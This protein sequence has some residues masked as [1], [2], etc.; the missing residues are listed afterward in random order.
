MSGEILLEEIHVQML[1]DELD[2]L[3]PRHGFDRDENPASAFSKQQA[4]IE[5]D[6]RDGLCAYLMS[7]ARA[8]HQVSGTTAASV[9]RHDDQD[10]ILRRRR[11]LT[12]VV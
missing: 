9:H 1:D 8:L 3:G 6:D 2:R 7:V 11:A 4:A 12:R 5:A 10:I